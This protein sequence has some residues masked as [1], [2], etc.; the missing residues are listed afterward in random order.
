MLRSSIRASATLAIALALGAGSASAAGDKAVGGQSAA[1]PAPAA[2]KGQISA[3][4]Y[5]EKAGAGDL[6]EVETGKLAMQ[7]ASSAEVKQFGE[8]MTKD[9]T[10]STEMVKQAA[11]TAKAK[12]KPPAPKMNS[13]Q[14]ALTKQLM[15][16]EGREFD[17]LYI[18]AQL[19]AHRQA[20]ELHR[21]YAANGDDPALKQA[22]AEI[23]PVVERHLAE[24]RQLSNAV[25]GMK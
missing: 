2:A 5:I 20:L 10:K 13:H 24:L 21:S 7:K 16:A 15:G 9:H 22:A 19:E 1:P 25:T 12:D 11:A 23:A 4:E 18:Q 3:R 14:Q 8:M 17:R 6:F